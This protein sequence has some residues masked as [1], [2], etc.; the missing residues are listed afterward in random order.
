MPDRTLKL[1]KELNLKPKI[2]YLD[3]LF[4][5]VWTEINTGTFSFR[6]MKVDN[7]QS[8]LPKNCF[9]YIFNI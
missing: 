1:F 8:E 6:F 7:I 4:F 9:F 2:Y 5:K 3:L